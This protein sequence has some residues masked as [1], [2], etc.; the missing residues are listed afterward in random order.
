MHQQ[1]YIRINFDIF[2]NPCLTS[3]HIN[4][5]LL[6]EIVSQAFFKANVIKITAGIRQRFILNE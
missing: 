6:T 2:I 1:R 4:A 3:K 5:N